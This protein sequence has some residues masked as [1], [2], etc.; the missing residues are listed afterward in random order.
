MSMTTR[1][2]LAAAGLLLAT[3]VL[4]QDATSVARQTMHEAMQKQMA[5]PEAQPTMPD[6]GMGD[7]AKVPDHMSREATGAG[8]RQAS[9]EMQHQAQNEMRHQ[10]E[11]QQQAEQHAKAGGMSQADA[12]RADAANRAAMGAGA[13]MG[14]DMM[15]GSDECRAADQQRMSSMHPGGMTDGGGSGGGMMSH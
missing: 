10:H 6:H 2:A 5:V 11:A 14:S 4:A 15:G 1:Y 13:G 12:T 8:P 9:H 7:P 3:P